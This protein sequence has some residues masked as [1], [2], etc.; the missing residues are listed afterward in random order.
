MIN[1]YLGSFE[2]YSFRDDARKG[3]VRTYE[4]WKRK[5]NQTKGDSSTVIRPWLKGFVELVG[6]PDVASH[7]LQNAGVFPEDYDKGEK[8][9]EYRRIKGRSNTTLDPQYFQ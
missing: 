5:S 2:S 8:I 3:G 1:H 9:Q 6:G 4:I 7:L